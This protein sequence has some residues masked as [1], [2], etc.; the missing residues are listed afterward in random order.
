M[1]RPGR[2]ASR[3]YHSKGIHEAARKPINLSRSGRWRREMSVTDQ[4]LVQV[5]AGDSLNALG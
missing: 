5:V 4:R 2:E 1:I 3:H